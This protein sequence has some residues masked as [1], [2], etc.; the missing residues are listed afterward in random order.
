M[1]LHYAVVG[2]GGI[3]GFYG[4]F[5]AK[6]G[7]QV[8]FLCH[9]DYDVVHQQGLRVDSVLGNFHLQTV[10]AYRNA[11]EM[12]PCDVVLVC[13]K[14]TNNHL[15]KTLLPPLLRKDTLVLLIQN[16]LG[17]EEDV[18]CDFP[19]Q[20]IAGGLAFICSAKSAP[21]HIS[22]LDYGKLT[23]GAYNHSAEEKLAQVADDFLQAGIEVERAPDLASARWKKLVWNIPFNGST[24]VLNATTKQ[25]IETPATCQLMADLMHEVQAGAAASGV[26]Y[27]ITDAFIENN[28]AMTKNMTPYS[29]SMKLDYD[30]HRPM[31]IEYIY[32]RALRQAT[33][34]GVT[35][36]KV[37]MLE[38]QLRF[39]A[40]IQKP[41]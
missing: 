34:A 13:L 32:T 3:G 39:L 27:P 18:Q 23:L 5:L 11:E 36:Q 7:A 10:N 12:S 37:A 21:G 33:E 41:F 25:L 9:S 6:A 20:P 4:G 26:A 2:L 1:S 8:D 14:T 24:V 28:L 17:V 40:D 22:H 19:E 29:P 16:G 15:L 38:Q 30:L 35:M 31:E